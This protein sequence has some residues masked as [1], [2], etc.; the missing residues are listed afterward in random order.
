[1][2]IAIENTVCLNAGD[3]AILYALM[4][5][6]RRVFGEDTEFIVFDSDPVVASRYLPDVDL[7]PQISSLLTVPRLPS[8]V[9]GRSWAVRLR[10]NAERLLRAEFY[11]TLRAAARGG[12]VQSL[13]LGAALKQNVELY[14][15]ADLVISTGGTYLVEHYNLD[16]RLLEFEKDMRLGKPLFLYTQSL[17]PFEDLRNIARLRSVFDYAELT[18]VREEKSRRHAAATGTTGNL[19][20]AADSVFVF[21][22]PDRMARA[23]RP[24]GR[25]VPTRVAVSV[26]EWAHFP[27]RSTEEGMTLYETAVSA[28]VRELIERYDTDITFI[29]T[30]QGVADYRYDDSKVAKRIAARLPEELRAKV[31]V[32][33]AFHA[34]LDLLRRLASFD[35]V[36]S[37]RMH[38]AILSLCA[39]VP[40]LPIAYEFKTTELFGSMG[41]ERWVTDIGAIDPAAFSASADAFAR[42]LDAFRAAVFPKVAELARSARSAADAIAAAMEARELAAAGQRTAA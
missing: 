22:D 36:I 17:G 3:A 4:Q 40:V 28:A 38:M 7:R 20:I 39:G 31:T 18:V 29:S 11:R 14:R 25:V 5:E 33:G 32:D 37:T 41:Q 15:K 23:A 13:L 6:M 9:F 26:R 30:C 10:R 19:A 2:L 16:G 1:M 8:R 34:P 35:F 42:D 24:K 12:E 27:G 21:A